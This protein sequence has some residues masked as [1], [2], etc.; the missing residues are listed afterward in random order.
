MTRIT[1]AIAAALI[2]FPASPLTAQWLNYPTF[3]LPRTADGKPNLAAPVPRTPDGKPD[4]S[5]LWEGK[6]V[7][8]SGSLM[9]DLAKNVPGGLPLTKWGADTLK[10]RLANEDKDDPDGYCQPLGLVRMHVHPYPRKIVQIPGLVLILFERDNIFRQIF[11]DGRPLPPDMQPSYNGYSTA[12]WD[13]DTLVVQTAG[14]KDG[15]WLDNVGNPITEGAKITE[16]F[17]RPSFGNL[18]IDVTVDDPKAYS[19]PWTLKLHQ[20][21]VTDTDMLEFFCTENNKDMPHMVGK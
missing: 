9:E 16:R 3:A 15:M 19:K 1:L 5:G 20:S 14:F 7:G 21:L 11:T 17:R 12:K 10:A 4:L 8:G 6:T 2:A 13:G 18:E